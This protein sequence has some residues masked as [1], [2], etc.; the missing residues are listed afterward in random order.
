MSRSKSILY[1][2]IGL[3]LAV[4]FFDLGQFEG[5]LVSVSQTLLVLF[6]AGWF[7]YTNAKQGLSFYVIQRL[8]GAIFVLF[9]I[10]T[11]TFLMLRFLP[12][13]PF[14]SDKA[15]P[16]E[17]LANIEK[18][19][20]L[21]KPL[22]T[23]Y[24]IYLSDLLQGDLGESYKYVGRGVTDIIAESL[25]NS[26]K[27]GTYALLLSFLI[28]IP[29]GVVAAAKHNTIWDT[30]A[31]FMA[32]SGVALPSFI[33]GPILVFIF[34][35]TLEWLDPALWEKPSHYIL[36]VVTLGLRPA[37]IIAR[38]ARSSAL[39][40]ISSDFVRTAKAK[41]LAQKVVLFKHVLRNSLIPVIT[42]SGPLVAGVLSGSFIIEIIFAVPGLGKHFVQSVTN[43]DYPLVLGVTLLYAGLLVVANLL[44]DLLYAVIDP[45]I[46]MNS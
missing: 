28:G 16:P 24:G 36:P 7:T 42:M 45:R 17:V 46:K 34:A 6:V 22:L 8:M 20:H 15:L 14:D 33:V 5:P 19:Y 32:I 26:L 40:V 37:A 44:V 25:P 10:A 12:G 9:I 29:L 38:L 21:D 30:S 11:T 2:F 27:L 1:T 31:M 35:Y 41:G 13:G 39:D 4:I 3:I 23:Q 18:K 43:R